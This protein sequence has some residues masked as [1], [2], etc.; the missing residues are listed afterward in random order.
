[1]IGPRRVRARA[2]AHTTRVRPAELRVGD[3]ERALRFARDLGVHRRPVRI[4][5]L[6][7]PALDV[8]LRIAA[9][10]RSEE[11]DHHLDGRRPGGPRHPVFRQSHAR[12]RRG[13]HPCRGHRGGIAQ[14]GRRLRQQR[15]GLG[16][17]NNY[18]GGAGK[19]AKHEG[20]VLREA[21][22][23]QR[24]RKMASSPPGGDRWQGAVAS[25]AFVDHATAT[26]SPATVR[27]PGDAYGRAPAAVTRRRS[28]VGT[29]APRPA[30][31]RA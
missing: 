3:R 25:V 4:A 16:E 22:V 13:T 10:P 6:A 1:M 5:E 29:G 14:E 12:T 15:R 31:W 28:S 27:L 26:H 24:W 17:G 9:L 23:A 20:K 18:G 30:P 8:R 2:G 21:N 19:V 7:V 11:V